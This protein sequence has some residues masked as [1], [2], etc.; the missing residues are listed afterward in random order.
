MRLHQMGLSEE[1][2]RKNIF[3]QFRNTLYISHVN[4]TS[5]APCIVRSTSSPTISLVYPNIQ[6][7]SFLFA[8]NPLLVQFLERCRDHQDC[9]DLQ[10]PLSTSMTKESTVTVAVDASLGKV[11]SLLILGSSYGD[12]LD[13]NAE[14]NRKSMDVAFKRLDETLLS[15]LQLRL[16]V[17]SDSKTFSPIFV[18]DV[19]E[20][21]R[22]DTNSNIS[23]NTDG[24]GGQEG[25][26]ESS[27][28][29]VPKELVRRIFES[30]VS[31]AAHGI[32][33]ESPIMQGALNLKGVCC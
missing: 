15:L 24:N 26:H 27:D 5:L 14:V 16:I 22:R 30:Q 32:V 10:V 1:Y 31:M 12:L 17:Y 13:R 3:W 25:A 6:R 19:T 2:M 4:S 9:E 18:K 8:T 28:K 11:L 23:S 21:S 7:K 29:K 20:V 33:N